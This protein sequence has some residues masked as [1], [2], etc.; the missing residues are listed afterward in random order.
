MTKMAFIENHKPNVIK[1]IGYKFF[2]NKTSIKI[3]E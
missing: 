2:A 1:S 3:K